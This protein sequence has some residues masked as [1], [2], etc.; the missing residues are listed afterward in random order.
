MSS[1]T[2]A[3]EPKLKEVL[4]RCLEEIR[5]TKAALYLTNGENVFQLITQYGFREIERKQIDAKDDLIDRI[6]MRRTPFFVNSLTEDPRF[7]QTLFAAGTTRMLIAPMYSRGKLIGFIDAR[8]KAAKAPFGAPDI[9]SAQKIVEQFL[10][11]FGQRGLFGQKAAPTVQHKTVLDIPTPGVSPAGTIEEARRAIARGVLRNRTVAESLT[12]SQLEAGAAVLPAIL[13]L[14][15]VH[16]AAL[17]SF[18][19][20]GGFQRIVARAELTSDA[21][22]KLEVKLKSWL[23]KR[24]DPEGLASSSIG[25]P[26]G[27]AP[28][29]VSAARIGTIQSAPVQVGSVRG[30]TLTVGFETPPTTLTRGLLEGLLGQCQQ[31]VEYAMSHDALRSMQIRVAEKLLEPDM[32]KFPA[33]VAHSK[34]VCESAEKLARFVGC[35]PSEVQ[36]AR[37]AGLVHDVGMR[38]LDYNNLYRKNTLTAEDLK[39]LR[40]HSIVGAALVADSPLGPEIA[41][42]VLCHHE[43]PDGTGYPHGLTGDAIPLISRIVHICESF[44]AMTASDS[45]Q[46]PVPAPAALARIRRVGGTQLDDQ[47]VLKFVEMLSTPEYAAR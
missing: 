13:T 21:R 5:A 37:V 17:S 34:R 18:A 9:E 47:L 38:L 22:Q 45:Y 16:F 28:V 44:D 32:Q 25:Y 31:I 14:P 23:Q 27:K 35:T 29:P 1:D 30:L 24:G 20:F 8:D 43:R 3:L 15:G 40:E 39:V 2:A 11:V 46:T 33:L 36:T 26:V 12:E 4:Y 7:S 41:H 10:D 19:K 6:L 42:I